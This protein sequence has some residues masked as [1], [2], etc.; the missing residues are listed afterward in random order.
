LGL[1]ND[2]SS[3]GFETSRRRRQISLSS[4]D[5]CLAILNV[6]A[7]TRNF[8][9]QLFGLFNDPARPVL[10]DMLLREGHLGGH[11]A[12]L[13]E[14]MWPARVVVWRGLHQFLNL[15]LQAFILE[16]CKGKLDA[17]VIASIPSVDGAEEGQ[18]LGVVQPSTNVAVHFVNLVGR[19][20]GGGLSKSTHKLKQK[21][22]CDAAF[23]R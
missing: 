20:G 9:S 4:R 5:R 19:M 16:M 22:I 18:P 2:A 23:Y 10:G 12:V 1:F 13:G 3:A 7:G 8:F 6:L 14:T 21:D 17:A 15:L 11:A